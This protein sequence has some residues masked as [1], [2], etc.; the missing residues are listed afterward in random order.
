MDGFLCSGIDRSRAY[1]FRPVRMSFCLSVRPSVRLFVCKNSYIHHIFLSLRV[2]VLIFH[3]IILCDKNFLLVT[4]SRSSVRS[5]SLFN[6]PLYQDSTHVLQDLMP[7]C[8]DFMPV[9]HRFCF[10]YIESGSIWI[11]ID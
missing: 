9:Y 2:K 5:I 3:M 7:V 10:V 1:S 8:Q 6:V 11:P 4:D